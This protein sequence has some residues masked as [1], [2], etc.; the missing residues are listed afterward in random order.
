MRTRDRFLPL[1]LL[2]LALAVPAGAS[3]QDKAPSAQGKPGSNQS[4]EKEKKNPYVERFKQLDRNGDGYVS[5]SE[6]PLD[7]AS[8]ERVDRNQDGRLSRSELLTPN[9]LRDDRRNEQ[10]QELDTNRD[11]RLSRTEQRQGGAGL[12]RLDRNRDGYIT[13]PEYGVQAGN[14]ENTWSSRSTVRDQR[15]FRDLDRNRDNR[16][17]L[18]EWTGDTTRFI[19]IDRNRDGLI[20]PNEWPR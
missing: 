20:S 18:L 14:G 3:A 2:A 19:Q 15:L 1:F 16:L 7:P 4:S 5:L 8:F 6:W 12:G 11:G 9:V 13:R 17:N 10:F